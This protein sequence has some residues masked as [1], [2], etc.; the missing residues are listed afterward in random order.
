MANHGD[1]KVKKSEI[2]EAIVFF[3]DGGNS[4]FSKAEFCEK[5]GASISAVSNAISHYY[6]KTYEE[7]IFSRLPNVLTRR[8]KF[9]DKRDFISSL[10]NSIAKLLDEDNSINSFALTKTNIDNKISG[11]SMGRLA[12]KYYPSAKEF[13]IAVNE[14]F[15]KERPDLTDYLV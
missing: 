11:G 9:N 5:V 1:Y 6:G 12:R 8:P 13:K 2:E 3:F 7:L 4:T 14:W 15:E 10:C